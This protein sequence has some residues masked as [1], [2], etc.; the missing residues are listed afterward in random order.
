MTLIVA[1]LKD[2][3]ISV[4][5]DTVVTQVDGSQPIAAT[6]VKLVILDDDKALG[7]AGDPGYARDAIAEF[8]K[9]TFKS[10]V[11]VTDHFLEWHNACSNATDFMLFYSK[12]SQVLVIKNRK[13]DRMTASRTLWIGDAPAFARFQ[14]YWHNKTRPSQVPVWEVPKILT[15]DS[16]DGSDKHQTF[17]MLLALRYVIIERQVPSV[18]GF[19]VGL[20][21][22]SGRFRFIK[23]AL[24]IDSEF[25]AIPAKGVLRLEVEEQQDFAQS[26]MLSLP[27]CGRQAI[28]FHFAKGFLSYLYLDN[29]MGIFDEVYVIA[30]KTFAEFEAITLADYGLKWDPFLVDKRGVIPFGIRGYDSRTELS[31]PQDRVNVVQV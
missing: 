27:E 18:A 15:N 11:E 26:C 21:N 31:G 20:S 4:V 16:I 7:F 8:R 5:C 19:T 2:E 12:P 3:V 24:V 1:K 22:V 25:R 28:A 23:F 10:R 30:D 9:G 6:L 14:I 13:V 29:G 17:R